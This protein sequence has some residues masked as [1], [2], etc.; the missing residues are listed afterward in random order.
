M[1]AKWIAQAQRDEPVWLPDVRSAWGAMPDAVAVTTELTLCGGGKRRFVIPVARWNGDAERAFV[2]EYLN[3]SV[4]NMLAALGGR[5]MCFYLPPT[6]HALRTLLEGLAD[7]FQV[8][9]GP[10]RGIGK[11][12]SV[13]NRICRALGE[14]AFRFTVVSGPPPAAAAPESM[15]A[16]GTLSQRLCAAARRA[17]A[18]LFCGVDIGGTDIKLALS[19]NGALLELR[20]FDWNPALSLTAD[21]I[22]DPI[23]TLIAEVCGGTRPDALGVS[24][25]DVVIR[26]RI[27]GGE[28]PKMHGMRGNA[29]RDFETEFARIS[30]LQARLADL[31]VPG[32][33][34]RLTNDGHMAAFS[35][36]M[37]LAHCGRGAQLSRGVVAH[38]LGTDLGTGWLN[39]D[40][41]IPE[42]PT[43]FYDM[44]L[45]LGSYRSR[46]LPTADL[47]C[48]RNENSGLGGAR[49]YLGQA[50]AFRL[51][52]KLKPALLDGFCTETDSGGICVRE[53][54][55][56]MRKACLEHLMR[57]AQAGDPAAE[58]V[59]RSIGRNLGEVSREMSFYLS[60]ATDTRFLFGRF[61][62][63]ARCFALLREGC[64][65]IMPQLHLEAADET[66]ACSGLMRQ[67][68]Q[69]GSAAVAH[70]AQAVGA[71]YFALMED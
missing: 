50:A 5:E 69:R 51:A 64:A 29:A 25:P 47:R 22:I 31:C 56:D 59:F 35:A 44:L 16:E 39:A 18:G 34:V 24:F 40:G 21:G 42:M 15:P 13:A 36:A 62:R 38:S 68:A 2:E 12:V 17:E 6:E 19:R 43:E 3:A 52:Y 14:G 1:I 45:D 41:S 28:T 61:V 60:P 49:R 4:F 27:V 37:E 32:A 46:D 63:H 65:E 8:N 10:R 53:Q 23:V 67:L 7:S 70:Y 54:P 48:V 20:E 26:N 71:I 55:E 57:S 30:A 33:P 9:T 66:L 58:E 11:A